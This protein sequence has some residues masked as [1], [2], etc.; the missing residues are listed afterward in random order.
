MESKK[1]DVMEHW[2]QAITQLALANRGNVKEA[3][4]LN[5]PM[6]LEEEVDAIISHS[7]IPGEAKLENQMF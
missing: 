4:R 6:L 3:V 5:G 7:V 1:L 2:L